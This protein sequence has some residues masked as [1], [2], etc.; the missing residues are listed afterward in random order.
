MVGSEWLQRWGGQW[1]HIWLQPRALRQL[2]RSKDEASSV[3]GLSPALLVTH[4]DLG[5]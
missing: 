3:L 2:G 1:G 5:D 4:H